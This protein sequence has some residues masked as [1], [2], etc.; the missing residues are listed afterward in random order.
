MADKRSPP[1]QVKVVKPYWERMRDRDISKT[2]DRL[3]GNVIKIEKDFL[4]LKKTIGAKTAKETDFGMKPE[5]LS[6]TI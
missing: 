6:A 3:L 4:N 5:H 2:N 1:I